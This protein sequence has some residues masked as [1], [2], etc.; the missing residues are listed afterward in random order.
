MYGLP[1]RW[2]YDQDGL[3]FAVYPDGSV[4]IQKTEERANFF[5]IV[6]D[7]IIPA[8]EWKKILAALSKARKELFGKVST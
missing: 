1:S 5:G 7:V 8:D 4:R 6:S 2:V 3:R